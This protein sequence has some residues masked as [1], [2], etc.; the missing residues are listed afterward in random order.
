MNALGQGR[1]MM[2]AKPL[3]IEPAGKPKASD[4]T[5]AK[6]G[7]HFLTLDEY[8]AL[9]H[10]ENPPVRASSEPDFRDGRNQR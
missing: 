10:A 8:L 2:P 5:A 7:R 1:G 3:P 9:V 6:L 4:N